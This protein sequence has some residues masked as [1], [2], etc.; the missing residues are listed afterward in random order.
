MKFLHGKKIA[1]DDGGK[2]R[3]L[4][5]CDHLFCSADKSGVD[6]QIF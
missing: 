5:V 3:T 1:H 2:S 4:W 6:R